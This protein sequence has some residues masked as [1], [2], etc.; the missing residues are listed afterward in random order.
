MNLIY[1]SDF[2]DL[3]YGFCAFWRGALESMPLQGV[4]FEIETE[5]VLSAVNAGLTIREVP[6]HELLR[7]A[8]TSNLNAFR[9]GR[10]VLRTIMEERPAR[11]AHRPARG[12]EIV[13]APVEVAMPGTDKWV[14]AGAD[15][16]KNDRR[17]L[18][19]ELTGYSGPERRLEDRREPPVHTVT[20][21]R[22]VPEMPAAVPARLAAAA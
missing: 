5:L 11:R 8:G 17:T 2:T 13:L 15:H 16:R 4:G 3:C 21:Y 20:V 7:R 12:A 19:A 18:D 6:S 10:R 22:V 1:G 9:D 14:P